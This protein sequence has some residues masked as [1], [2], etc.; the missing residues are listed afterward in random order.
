MSLRLRGQIA[1]RAAVRLVGV[2]EGLDV[3]SLAEREEFNRES[4]GKLRR[5]RELLN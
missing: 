4:D 3:A 1:F 2:H 5:L